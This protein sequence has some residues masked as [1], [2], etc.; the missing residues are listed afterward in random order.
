VADLYGVRHPAGM[1]ER[2]LIVVDKAGKVA[3]IH[4]HRP[5]A[6]VPDAEA[7]FEVLRKL[8]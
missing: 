3:W 5:T 8:P 1:P 6:E 7:M 2:A 4:V